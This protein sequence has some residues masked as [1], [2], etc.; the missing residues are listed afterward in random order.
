MS[1]SFRRIA[2]LSAVMLASSAWAS[3]SFANRSLGV[4]VSGFKLVS[5]SELIDWGVPISIEG[6]YYLDNGFEA[7]VR[8]SFMF[9]YQRAFVQANGEGGIVIAGGG[10]VGL[11]YLFS[12]ESLRPYVDLHFAGFYVSR[13]AT[14]Q[15]TGVA[16]NGLWGPGVSVGLDYFVGDSIS[17]GGRAYVDLFIALNTPLRWALGGGLN[18]ATYF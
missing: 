12:E 8:A 4:S 13:D 16:P 15:G 6:G 7:F 1:A 18:V 9:A 3:A 14:L 17:I 2:M 10:Q 5:D 11:R